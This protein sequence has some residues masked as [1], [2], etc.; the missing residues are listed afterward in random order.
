MAAMF[1]LCAFF[2]VFFGILSCWLFFKNTN[3]RDENEYLADCNRKLD[4]ENRSFRDEQGLT[5]IRAKSRDYETGLKIRDDDGCMVLRE[6][7]SD[8]TYWG[9]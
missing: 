2:T 9:S 8:K 1:E 4:C 5:T 6:E 7:I 3:L